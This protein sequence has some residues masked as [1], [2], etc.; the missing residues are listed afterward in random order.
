MCRRH[1]E[2]NK[3]FDLNNILYRRLLCEIHASFVNFN[4][5]RKIH[6]DTVFLTSKREEK[7]MSFNYI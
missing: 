2:F 7:K 1:A 6:T 4:L 3:T 5:Q